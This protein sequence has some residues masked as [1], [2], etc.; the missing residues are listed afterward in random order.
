MGDATMLEAALE[1]VSCERKVSRSRKSNRD[2][3][4]RTRARGLKQES[5]DA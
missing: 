3:Y 1:I 2:Q 4:A 5:E